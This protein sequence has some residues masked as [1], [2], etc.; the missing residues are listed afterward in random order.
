MSRS[1]LVA[2]HRQSLSAR[3]RLS[4]RAVPWIVGVYVAVYLAWL[5]G[6]L[7]GYGNRTQLAVLAI[8]PVRFA[9]VWLALAVARNARL[10]AATRQAW[11]YL[12]AAL[13][14]FA[15]GTTITAVA[16]LTGYV[17]PYPSI[18]DV[19]LLAFYPLTFLGLVRLPSKPGTRVDR[20]RL[21]LDALI[22]TVGGG[23]VIWFVVIGSIQGA[24]AGDPLALVTSV[25]YPL[26]DLLILSGLATMILRRSPLVDRRAMGLLVIGIG[27]LFAD[28]L[29][30]SYLQSTGSYAPGHPIDGLWML[31]ALLLALAARAQ[32]SARPVHITANANAWRNP[33]S[34]APY[35]FLVAGYLALVVHSD[36]GLSGGTRDLIVGTAILAGLVGGRQFLALREN[37][38][39]LE[40]QGKRRSE[41][42]FSSLVEHASDV[43]A[44]VG[45]G[46]VIRYLSP[47]VGRVLGYD[48]DRLVGMTLADLATT[49]NGRPIRSLSDPTGRAQPVALAWRMTHADGHLIDIEAIVTDLR[50]D[51]NVAG[52]VLNLRDVSERRTFEDQL[53][54][55]AFHDS[56]TSLAN[57]VLFRDRVEH[58]LARRLRR[59]GRLA[60]LFVDLDDFKKVNDAL[61][62]AA[63][64][65]LLGEVARRLRGAVRSADT[66]ARLG[67]DEFGI[68]L[69][70]IDDV[71]SI[72]CAERIVGELGEPY[73]LRDLSIELG[74]SIGI[75]LHDGR[76]VSADDLLRDAD[77]ALYRAKAAGKGRHAVFTPEMHIAADERL[78]LETDLRGALER[79]E[80]KLEYQPVLDLA[81]GGVVSTEALVRWHHPARGLLS[82]LSFIPVAEATGLIVPI[83][84]WVLFE[85]CRQLAKWHRDR[86]DE[87]VSVSVNLSARQL[88]APD[89]LADVEQAIARHGLRPGELILEI[90]ESLLVDARGAG[91]ET[92]G[93]LRSLGARIAIDDFGTGYSA[94]AYLH[95]FPSDILKI[96]KA[97]V[98]GLDGDRENRDV[99]EAVVQIGHA[100]GMQ[101]VAEGVERKAQLD[102]LRDTGCDMGQ[103]YLLG[104]P[105][106]PAAFEAWRAR[107]VAGAVVAKAGA[108]VA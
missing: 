16:T 105:M 52:F 22:W 20:V 23:L 103:G 33:V 44:V 70:D 42:R 68:L 21:A 100:L 39:L 72:A 77:V 46:D 71:E 34:L 7:A 55:Q 6:P 81:H 80:F 8:L 65:D 50:T 26:G 107:L 40:E 58:A 56:L 41:A 17:L 94:L 19:A 76:S 93:R 102:R 5:V 32:L 54:H 31:S 90:T 12:A 36:P 30:W 15:A 14:V 82:P 108:A 59:P 89:L 99:A 106:A 4:R 47:A 43:I 88:A 38:H 53:V 84:R 11:R 35:V 86:P 98:D 9:S 78:A 48:A 27:A 3:L 10:E 49:T 45:P 64:D 37:A 73:R 104:R 61:G 101:I 66:V 57:R 97:F 63:G 2:I 74:A 75:A 91:A 60:V 87:R 79:G 25:A 18:V 92:L 28:D 83:G 51:P 67:G 85:A 95:R 62:H 29:A 1:S 69:E 13:L 24:L 96:D